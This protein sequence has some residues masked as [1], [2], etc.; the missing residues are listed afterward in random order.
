MKKWGHFEEKC[1][2]SKLIFS[3][4]AYKFD[5]SEVYGKADS[6]R[7]TNSN[8]FYLTIEEVFAYEK[9]NCLPEDHDQNW[10]KYNGKLNQLTKQLEY[11][12]FTD[13]KRAWSQGNTICEAV[14]GQLAAITTQDEQDLIES[15]LEKSKSQITR[16]KKKIKKLEEKPKQKKKNN[17]VIHVDVSINIFS[18]KWRTKK[19]FP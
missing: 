8:L 7:I 2:N 14:G 15:E 9:L 17:T 16:L 10:L 5:C 13:T 4:G 11:K 3:K 18:K 6:I 1:E 19:R 12:L